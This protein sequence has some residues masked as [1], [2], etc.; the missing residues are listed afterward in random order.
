[1]NYQA[2][3]SMIDNLVKNYKCNECWSS[4]TE[5][6]IDIVWAAWNSVNIDVYC[7]KCKKHAMVKSQVLQIDITNF[8]GLK[9]TL[10]NINNKKQNTIKD[11]EM[12]KL[13]KELKSRNLNAKDLFSD[14]E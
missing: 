13:S 11:E 6:D 14:E 9:N 3:K 5:K 2:L 12:I 7:P 8:S 10:L 1:M 4:I